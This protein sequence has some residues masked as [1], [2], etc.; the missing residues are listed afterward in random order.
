MALQVQTFSGF[1]PGKWAAFVA[2]I[3]ADTGV[4]I[5]AD[6]GTVTHGSFEFTYAYNEAAS[7][8]TVQCLKKPLF[9]KASVIIEG[10]AEEIADLVPVE[11]TPTPVTEPVVTEPAPVA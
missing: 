2:K 8:L 9:I 4:V 6:S 1:T 7:T 10:L 3:K 11:P 5:T